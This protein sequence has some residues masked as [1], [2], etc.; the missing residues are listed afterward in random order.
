MVTRHQ[1]GESRSIDI[2]KGFKMTYKYFGQTGM[3]VSKLSYG[4]WINKTL[5]DEEGQKLVSE[6]VKACYDRGINFF[7]TAE[8]YLHGRSEVFLGNA[9]K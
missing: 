3:K 1:T 5:T 9:L 4:T 6:C 7:D 2:D 8:E